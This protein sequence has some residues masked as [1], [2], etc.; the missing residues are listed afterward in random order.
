MNMVRIL[1][2]VE[3][4]AV[5]AASGET[6][7][8][9]LSRA[10][11][12]PDAP[13]GGRGTCGKCRVTVEGEVSDPTEAERNAVAVGQRLA[14]QC[15][16]AGDCTVTVRPHGQSA[17]CTAGTGREFP[18][19]P[20]AGLGAAV[21]IGTTT[22]VLYLHDLQTGALLA[23]ESA[24][25]AQRAH[26]ADV[27]SRIS[28]GQ[29]SGFQA[30]YDLTRAQLLS[31]LD[32][33]CRAAGRETR[34]VYTWSIVGNTVMLHLLAG[35]SPEPIA[36]APFTPPRLFGE[37][38]SAASIGL[39]GETAYLAPCVAGYVGGDIT[40]G[41]LAVGQTAE[42][43]LFLDVG[44]NGE[45]AV[46]ANGRIVC[47]ATAAGPAFEGAEISCGMAARDGA[48]DRVT[49]EN[50]APQCHVLGGGA[51]TG[52]CGSGLVDAVAMLL[53]LGAV[54]ETGRL[55]PADE[56]PEA[57]QPYLTGDGREVR[58]ALSGGV[59]LSAADVRQ[60]QLA[61]GA[62][63]AGVQ[64][65]LGEVGLE[66]SELTALYLAGGFGSYLDR[67]S[68]A[69]IG[70]F[71]PELVDRVVVCGNSAGAGA[72]AVLCSAAAREE[73]AKLPQQ[74]QYLELSGNPR[75]TDAYMDTM[76]FEE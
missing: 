56:A 46:Q 49:W 53:E 48:I 7:L 73:L 26:G 63:A 24:R 41:L 66:A 14:C 19:E 44:T 16:V 57:A 20:Q 36:F 29:A 23:T 21:D 34:E 11:L 6:L 51:A 61:K 27:I 65:L 42:P 22:V 50:G 31:L 9:I 59:Y 72:Q 30:L 5:P 74:M 47:C 17:I 45:M 18:I 10:G 62:I 37:T 28:Y 70:L 3:P 58:F 60:L 25:N 68:A 33:A 12:A 76:L 35:V 69:R 38:V 67:Q 40:A 8:A 71:P 2:A 52:L 39:T 64:T 55:L 54:D 43:T 1:G 4:Q 13:C 32:A 15:R 75:F